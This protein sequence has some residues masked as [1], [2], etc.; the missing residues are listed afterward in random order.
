MV[1]D[2]PLELVAVGGREQALGHGYERSPV[3]DLLSEL[4]KARRGQTSINWGLRPSA[5][6]SAAPTSS[7][8]SGWGRSGRLLNSGWA[9][10]PIQQGCPGSSMN[11]TSRSSGEVP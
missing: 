8:N 11:S 4:S 5:R 9:W 10:V 1:D 2:V 6:S 3:E 7:K